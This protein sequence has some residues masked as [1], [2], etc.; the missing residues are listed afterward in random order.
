MG[1]T[2]CC[3]SE[4]GV[5]YCPVGKFAEICI[6]LPAK[7]DQH[8]GPQNGETVQTEVQFVNSHV[9]RTFVKHCETRLKGGRRSSI[10]LPIFGHDE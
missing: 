5:M 8:E 2:A 9:V 7:R 1:N 4:A 10:H 6:G 3:Q